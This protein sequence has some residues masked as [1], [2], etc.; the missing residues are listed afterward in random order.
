[1]S[2]PTDNET[3]LP[4]APPAGDDTPPAPCAASSSRAGSSSSRAILGG[5]GLYAVARAAGP[6]LLLFLTAAIIALILNP[7]VSTVAARAGAPRARDPRRVRRLLRDAGLRR[8]AA[9]QPDRRPVLDVPRRRAVDRALGERAAR[10]RAALLRPQEHQHPGHEAGPDR[11]ADAPAAR[12]RRHRPGRLLRHRPRD[13]RGHRRVRGD[14]RL[15]AVGLH[16]RLRRA[17]RRPRAVGDAAG[18]RDPRGRLPGP[19]EPRGRRLRARPDPVQ[20]GDG[21]S[22]PGSGCTSSGRSGSSPTARP[23]RWASACS[24][25]SWS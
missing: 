15:R 25:G 7:L 13:P 12:R 17:D 6:V 4:A 19:R 8:H 5:L 11:A 14:P 24:S 22:A 18:G 20:R 21:R 23:T 1:M 10:R 9:R 2:E 16:A 3:L